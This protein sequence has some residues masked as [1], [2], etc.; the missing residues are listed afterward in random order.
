MCCI[1][2]RGIFGRIALLIGLFAGVSLLQADFITIFSEDWES[3]VVGDNADQLANWQYEPAY[4]NGLPSDAVILTDAVWPFGKFLCIDPPNGYG[5]DASM[6][7]HTSGASFLTATP[8][9]ILSIKSKIALNPGEGGGAGVIGFAQSVH[10]L[11]GYG[12]AVS[13]SLNEQDGFDTL[14]EIFEFN[15][16]LTGM[17]YGYQIVSIDPTDN[18]NVHTFELQAAILPDSIDLDVYWD[19]TLVPQLNHSD[20]TPV[21]FGSGVIF[22][23]ATNIGQQ[24]FFD[25]FVA[26]DDFLDWPDLEGSDL[27]I[28]PEG[29]AG[30]QIAVGWRVANVGDGWADEAWVDCL[31]ASYD[32]AVG[33]DLPLG[34]FP[35]LNTLG[36]DDWYEQDNVEV[37]IPLVPEG[38][39]WVI[40]K[41]NDGGIQYE[42][43][44]ANNIVIAGPITIHNANLAISD[45]SIPPEGHVGEPLEI[46]WTVTNTGDAPTVGSWE[47]CGFL[48]YDDEVGDDEPLGCLE[49]PFGLGI[50]ESYD[51]IAQGWVPDV[52]E[53]DYWVIVHCDNADIL[54]ETDEGDN[55]AIVG[56]IPIYER[57][58][59]DLEPSDVNVPPDPVVAGGPAVVDWVVTNIGNVPTNTP[60]WFDRIYLSSDSVLSGDDRII[61]PDIINPMALNSNGA[62]DDAYWQIVEFTVPDDLVGDYFVIIETD[63]SEMLS[64]CDEGNNVVVSDTTM[65]IEQLVGPILAM[66]NCEVDEPNPWRGDP[67]TVTW[68]VTNIGEMPTGW[69]TLDHAIALSSDDIIDPPPDGDEVYW[70]VIAPY[71]YLDPL[72]TSD[73]ISVEVH[74][75]WDVW[76]H[77]FLIVW[78]DPHLDLDMDRSPCAVPINIQPGIPSDLEVEDISL[79]A[80]AFSGQ[81]VDITWTIRNVAVEPTHASW[82]ADDVYLS[83]DDSLETTADNHL[84][85]TSPHVGDLN[86]EESYVGPE[87]GEVVLPD[88][89]DGLYYLIVHTDTDNRVY[90]GSW[91]DNNVFSAGP[92]DVTYAPPDLV[93]DSIAVLQNDVPVSSV[94]SGESVTVEWTVVNDGDGCTSKDAWSDRIY[95]STDHQLH[96]GLDLELDTKSHSGILGPE[97]YYTVSRE[98]TI[99]IEF[100]GSDVYIFVCTDYAKQVYEGDD[101]NNCE[102]GYGFEVVWAPPDLLVQ[103]VEVKQDGIAVETVSS[104]SPITVEWS[105]LNNDIGTTPVNSWFDR[106][107]LSDDVWLDGSDCVLGTRHH[108]GALDYGDTY[109][110]SYEVEIPIYVVGENMF[111]FVK[112]DFNNDVYEAD[113]GNNATADGP[114]QV[115][116]GPPNLQVDEVTAPGGVVA[117]E[118]FSVSW[119]VRNGGGPTSS[120]TWN[121]RVYL[122]NDRWLDPGDT[123]FNP[124]SHAG[125]LPYNCTYTA[126]AMI[127]APPGLNDPFYVIIEAD[128]G[129][130]VAESNECDNTDYTSVSF[131]PDPVDLQVTNVNAPATALSGQLMQLSWTVAN[132]GIGTTPA[133]WCDAVYLSLDKYFDP[134]VDIYAGYFY[135]SGALSGAGSPGDSYTRTEWVPVENGLSG[136]Y[137]VF[138]VTDIND[139]VHEENGAGDAEENNTGYDSE[140]MDVQIPPP[141]DLIVIDIDV[142]SNGTLGEFVTIEW[143][144]RN[145]GDFPAEGNWNDSVFLSADATWDI[146]DKHVGIK[147]HT[148]PLYVGGQYI[149]SLTAPL[150][151]VVPG[152]YHVIIRT[153]IHN[154]VRETIDGEQNNDTASPGTLA[155]NCWELHLGIPDDSHRLVSGEEHFFQITGV[156][157]DSDD[158]LVQLDCANDYAFTELYI[159]RDAIPDRGHYDYAHSELLAADHEIPIPAPQEGTYYI[160]V[161]GTYIPGGDSAYVLRADL[162]PFEVRSVQP[163][164]IGDTGPSTLTI[165]GGSFDEE[166]TTVLRGPSSEEVLSAAR[167]WHDPMNIIARFD[168]TGQAQGNWDVVVINPGRE[169][170]VL[171]D[172]VQVVA[173]EPGYA[174]ID[175][176]GPGLLR[177]N[178]WAHLDFMI[179][180]P[181][182]TDLER[183]IIVLTF[184]ESM[185]VYPEV[186]I[187]VDPEWDPLDSCYLDNDGHRVLQLDCFNIAPHATTHLDIVV[188]PTVAGLFSV[189][190]EAYLL[191][192]E[193]CEALMA[194]M[195]E[196]GLLNGYIT[197]DPPDRNRGA[198]MRDQ[199]TDLAIAEYLYYRET[200][201]ER[202]TDG[203][204]LIEPA[205]D[206]CYGGLGM[207]DPSPSDW[208]GLLDFAV[209][210][211]GVVDKWRRRDAIFFPGFTAASIDPNAKMGPAGVGD[212]MFV[213]PGIDLP[214]TVEFENLPEADAPAQVVTVVDPLDVDLD[215][216][217]FRLGEIVF[218][219]TRIEACAGR[220]HYVGQVELPNGLLVRINAGLNI[221]TGTATWT[222]TAIDP[223]TGERPRNPMLGLLPPNDPL[224]HDGEGHVAFTV[225]ARGDVPG[226][227]EITNSATI[228]FDI[229]EPINTNEIFNTIDPAAPTSQVLSLPAEQPD[230]QFDV[231]WEGQD[232]ESGSGIASYAIYYSEDGSL[233][234]S[235]ISTADTQAPFPA[236]RGGGQYAFYS[237]AADHAGNT[238]PAPSVPDTTVTVAVQVPLAPTTGATTATTVELVTPG[239]ANVASIEHV[240]YVVDATSNGFYI[241]PYG[242]LQAH[243]AW[244]PLEVWADM[245]IAA[246]PTET[247]YT[248]MTKARSIDLIETAFGPAVVV[249]TSIPGD[250]DGDRLVSCADHNL[251]DAVL[252]TVPEDPNWDPR[253]DLDSNRYVTAADRRIVR[254][255]MADFDRDAD[256]DL[257]DFAEFQGCFSGSGV[258]MAPGCDTFDFEGDQDVDDTDYAAF[259]DALTGPE[260]E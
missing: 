89:A 111:V 92:F 130:D 140:A 27:D 55:I 129:G 19:D 227:T 232:D 168:M 120:G 235:W 165:Q 15:G 131:T 174:E 93:V 205:I 158:I 24:A 153:D 81:P 128:T 50:S 219:D 95:L 67:V 145:N 51:R 94:H 213:R 56:P 199:T 112:T 75:P 161:I 234:V 110:A 90:E 35:R 62:Y 226:G 250:A 40:L 118:P 34:C 254:R 99:P 252:G 191:T 144:V 79:P 69:I 151:G 29:D 17:G 149:E 60:Y 207:A 193:D 123:P 14:L 101:G 76:G 183:M 192:R 121:D 218:G 160:Q 45:V 208:L 57:L 65:H 242:L 188:R 248:I 176:A 82:W 200:L 109:A 256:I 167:A 157:A 187:P 243:P 37:Y 91:E 217:T 143:A 190:L 166:A 36:P 244:Q 116:W 127:T 133:G 87:L 135:H 85:G 106:V 136:P 164:V 172:G 152:D 197:Y 84:L 202:L 141:S 54:P 13:R 6:G 198:N 64:E 146:T 9:K 175:M 61:E 77:Y 100:H 211:A 41:V 70:H 155:V 42:L 177:L 156:P 195:I 178:E 59:A 173:G 5:P 134:L 4:G 223:D 163:N 22:S 72:G 26:A 230:P 203:F 240:V 104:G 224:I 241:G 186:A 38:D 113:N 23:L 114:I 11:Y 246:L 142:P 96:I 220:S 107:Y 52:P 30:G 21:D 58:C 125:D 201:G 18:T 80:E 147:R 126:G 48:S 139:T 43:N 225:R 119:R 66:T 169:E 74:L 103:A 222:L 49:R 132:L 71:L 233:Y 138:V 237:T 238:E 7:I 117:G 46:H 53:G 179:H 206:I 260:P 33:D 259:L 196:N 181:T 12:L 102:H 63:A 44:E 210:G 73:E 32:E 180:N 2:S 3:E 239:D 228:I 39:Y 1:C 231:Q 97:G 171:F 105:V 209:Q 162:L 148:G 25:D 88:D 204:G 221:E 16:D 214:F 137:Y 194:A 47:D 115:V 78:P 255:I 150:P 212:Q 86:F 98:V 170:A 245:R 8:G 154:E 189:G 108:F 216:R 185:D 10:P 258:P 122:S 159:R 28:P 249:E 31:W 68:T 20:T 247:Q 251:V 182:N 83:R 229:N 215:W 236:A 253:A 257:R 124:V 184:P